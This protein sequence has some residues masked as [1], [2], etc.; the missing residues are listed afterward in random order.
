[1]LGANN[2]LARFRGLHEGGFYRQTAAEN[3][4]LWLAL[5]VGKF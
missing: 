4:T 1:M 3:I 5:G 2:A